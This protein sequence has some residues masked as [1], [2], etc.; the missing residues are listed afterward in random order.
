MKV[1]SPEPITAAEC[2]RVLDLMDDPDPA[3]SDMG[4]RQVFDHYLA[5]RLPVDRLSAKQQRSLREIVDNV[6]GR[7]VH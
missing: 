2:Q 7:S 3:I 1:D 4:Y 5:G 6:T